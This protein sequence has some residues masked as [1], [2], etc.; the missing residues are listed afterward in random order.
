MH[1]SLSF[2]FRLYS[3]IVADITDSAQHSETLGN[4][5]FLLLVRLN[6]KHSEFCYKF[7]FEHWIIVW[8]CTVWS[9]NPDKAICIVM[10][11]VDFRLWMC[12]D[13]TE[14][15]LMIAQGLS[16]LTHLIKY[17][18]KLHNLYIHLFDVE[19]D[20]FNRCESM[21]K[22]IYCRSGRGLCFGTIAYLQIR[23]NFA[24]RLPKEPSLCDVHHQTGRQA[25]DGDQHVSEGEIHD[26]IIGHG[27]HVAVFPHCKTNWRRRTVKTLT[28]GPKKSSHHSRALTSVL[29]VCLNRTEY[30]CRRRS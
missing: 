7:H 21:D 26:E 13:Q 22:S 27:A 19:V 8:M 5:G 25:D 20:K 15:D 4:V 23:H 6:W 16:N 24:K 18:Q 30:I 29:Q 10:H 1:Y 17:D 11:F 28:W 9:V 3:R 2:I 12:S 14:A